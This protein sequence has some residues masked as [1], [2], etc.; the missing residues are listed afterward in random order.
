MR[1]VAD[2]SR[3]GQYAGIV[4]RTAAFVLDAALVALAWTVT[5][6]VVSVVMAVLDIDVS[7]WGDLG[8]VLAAGASTASVFLV[9]YTAFLFL[10][11]KT[12][13]MLVLGI[14]V[15]QADGHPPRLLRAALR[16]LAFGLSS[17]L[18]LGFV[19]VA[20]DNR[21]QAWHDKVARTFVVYDWA[22]EAGTITTAHLGDP[23]VP[24]G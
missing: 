5:L 4:S 2:A 10:F 8:R 7:G 24:R 12:P 22:A 18:M 9:Y 21:R 6:F 15:V 14:R 17:V 19:W 16:T 1:P 13:G 11:G 20:I 3:R 23:L